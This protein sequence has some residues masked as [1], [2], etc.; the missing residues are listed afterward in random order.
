MPG[1]TALMHV[2]R[3]EIVDVEQLSHLGGFALPT[4]DRYPWPALFTSTSRPPQASAAALTAAGDRS[5]SVTSRA[6]GRALAELPGEVGDGPPVASG[7]GNLVT[8]PQCGPGDLTEA[9]RA[10][11]DQ[12]TT[13]TASLRAACA[14]TPAPKAASS[15]TAAVRHRPVSGQ[16]T[17]VSSWSSFTTGRGR[18]GWLWAGLAELRPSA[19]S[20]CLP[21]SVG[22]DPVGHAGIDGRNNVAI[23]AAVVGTD[24]ALFRLPVRS[25][26]SR[27]VP[28][29]LLNGT[30]KYSAPPR[31]R[32][33]RRMPR[34][35]RGRTV[36]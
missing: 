22:V 25:T 18:P 12:P 24:C 11:G 26:M 35:G 33:R 3:A 8:V 5:P 34:R 23:A 20:G 32:R 4:A 15:A 17:S 31:R 28:Q 9:G 30:V 21:Q 14:D 27:V 19:A 6:S 1:S 10:A 13:S 29:M 7:D 16:G 36:P 2:D